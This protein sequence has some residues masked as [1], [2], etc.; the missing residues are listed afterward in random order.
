MDSP[1]D[2]NFFWLRGQEYKIK[3]FFLSLT[4]GSVLLTFAAVGWSNCDLQT[5]YCNFANFWK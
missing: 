4:F 3:F 2:S 5:I 1:G